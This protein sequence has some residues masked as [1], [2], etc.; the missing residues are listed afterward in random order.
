MFIPLYS[1]IRIYRVKRVYTFT[2]PKRT[3]PPL[4]LFTYGR[5]SDPLFAGRLLERRLAA[6]PA[7]L[8]EYVLAQ[9][10][11]VDD[12]V[13]VPAP[14]RQAEGLLYRFLTADDFDRLDAYA[15]VAEGVYIRQRAEARPTVGGAVEPVFVFIPTDRAIRGIR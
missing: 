12:S 2:S 11:G 4:P 7:V 1:I 3:P 8:M 13:A 15:G 9:L 10:P 6:E 5:L 14:G